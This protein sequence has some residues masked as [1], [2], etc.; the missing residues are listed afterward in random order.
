MCLFVFKWRVGSVTHRVKRLLRK[1]VVQLR[2]AVV[3]QGQ[4]SDTEILT[5]IATIAR[6][7]GQFTSIG[8]TCEMYV[9]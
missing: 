2:V 8:C 4:V 5:G 6:Q 7:S 9:G 1:H 3:A